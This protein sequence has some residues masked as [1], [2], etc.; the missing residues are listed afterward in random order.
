MTDRRQIQIANR[1]HL[2]DA[3]TRLLPETAR[4]LARI[5]PG[6]DETKINLTRINDAAIQAYAEQWGA[7]P[8]NPHGDFDWN[9]NVDAFSRET[10]PFSVAIWYGDTLCG[11]GVGVKR[12]G[13]VDLALMEGSPD[14]DH[15]LKGL[16]AAIVI[17]CAAA[18]AREWRVSMLRLK[19]PLEALLPFYESKLGFTIVRPRN[20]P[21]YCEREV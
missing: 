17:D 14:P 8:P 5:R 16:I 3:L 9:Y 2:V 4:E 19:K 20:Q 21:I 10:C 13:R 15:P 11:L 18:F 7:L 12:N 1:R 6:L